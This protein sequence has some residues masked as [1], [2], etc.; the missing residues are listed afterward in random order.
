MMKEK[1]PK[2]MKGTKKHAN[3]ECALYRGLL[4][5]TGYS[6]A[7]IRSYTASFPRPQYVESSRH[8]MQHEPHG[9]SCISCHFLTFDSLASINF[10]CTCSQK[11]TMAA[12][13]TGPKSMQYGSYR[14]CQIRG[15]KE[16]QGL[17]GRTIYNMSH[18][19][20]ACTLPESL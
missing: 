10:A 17:F 7:L 5:H 9:P 8:P 14:S 1:I 18:K 4:T 6:D 2:K 16:S 12:R 19:T 15:T 20:N 3:R 13:F 11:H